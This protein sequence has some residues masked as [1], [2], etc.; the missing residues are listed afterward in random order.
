MDNQRTTQARPYL[1]VDVGGTFTD[2]AFYDESGELTCIKVA[3]TP[4][5]PGLSTLQGVNELRRLSSCTDAAWSEM[6]HTHSNT[7]AVNCLIERTGAKLGLLVTAGFRDTLEIAR[8]TIPEP[9]RYD[10][11]RPVPLVPRR[12]VAGVEERIDAEGRV[13]KPLDAESTVAAA[14]RLG[15]LGCEILVIC[16]L[17]SYKNPAHEREA[18]AAIERELPGLPVEISSDVWPQAREFERAT[19]ALVNAHIRPAVERQAKLLVGG[20]AER[21]VGTPA[22]GSRS[23]GGMELLATMAERP[24]TA[25]LSGPAAGVAGAAAAAADAGWTGANLMTLDVGGTSADIG[26]VRGGR[27]VLSAEERVADFP[28]L[29]PTVA[30]SAIGAGGGSIIWTDATGALKIGPKSTGADPGP[31]CYGLKGGGVA[32]MTDAFLLAGLLNPQRLLGGRMKVHPDRARRALEAVGGQVGLSPEQVADGA[33]QVATAMLAAESTSVLARRD[34]DLSRYRMVA[35]G[36]AGPL[37]AALVAEAVYVNSVLIPPVPGTLSALGAAQADLE[38]D[39]VQPIYRGLDSLDAASLGGALEGIRSQTAGWLEREAVGLRVQHAVVEY[40]A[41]MRYEGQGFDVTVP[42]DE[43]WLAAGD[44]AAILAAFHDA[45]QRAFG[46]SHRGTPAWLQELRAHLTGRLP[47]PAPASLQSAE[48]GGDPSIRNIRL[49]GKEVE[50]RIFNRED[51]AADSRIAGP[52]IVEQM[53]T[54]TLVPDGWMLTLALNGAL[55]LE[56]G[57]A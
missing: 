35:Y 43:A 29:V 6:S 1:G 24:V 19:L 30:V 34:V 40:S 22:R 53:D 14:A 44:S 5:T 41:E 39:F 7:V 45:H 33:I 51:I 4:A 10:S 26:V 3:S 37:V 42:I 15:E 55:I 18:R 38:G 32:A 16:F 13:V 11:R 46:H 17:H 2:L 57:A 9:A 36:G 21:G 25:L 27:P 48:V 50:G 49:R 23:N 56:R 54:T 28:I 12:R 31:A 20:M 52:A 8:M 47:K